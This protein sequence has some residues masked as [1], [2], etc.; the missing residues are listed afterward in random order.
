MYGTLEH[1]V[2]GLWQLRFTRTFAHPPEKVWRAITEPEHL[3]HWFPTTIEGER[4]A[5]ARLR[6]AFPGGEAPAFDGEMLACEPPRLLELRWGS[7]VLRLELR[8]TPEGTVLT[9]LDTLD[10]RGK[11]ARDGAGWHVCLQSLAEHLRGDA[12]PRE[13]MGAAWNEVHPHYV[14]RFGPEAATIGPPEG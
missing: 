7:D 2:G 11:G 10:D 4:T 5:G 3:A 13:S 14:E 6:F 8:P 1:L 12:N 9:L